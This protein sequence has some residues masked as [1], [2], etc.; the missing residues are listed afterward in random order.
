[1]D[2]R[3]PVCNVI[4]LNVD[5]SLKKIVKILHALQMEETEYA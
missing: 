1:M 5:V 3:K 4:L 2:I